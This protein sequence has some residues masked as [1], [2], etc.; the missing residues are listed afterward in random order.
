M[1]RMTTEI[2]VGIFVV[3]GLLTLIYMTATIGKWNLGRSKGYLVTARL[4]SASGLLKDSPVK[5]L[6][7]SKGKIEKL[8]IEKGKAK[9]YMRLPEELMLPKDSLVFV[10]SEGLLGEKYIEIKPGSPD[11]PLITD[12][13]ELLQ[14]APP[15]DLDELFSELSEVARSIK[16]L[17]QIIIQPADQAGREKGKAGAIQSI[18]NNLEKTSESLKNLAQKIEKGEGTLGKLLTDDAMYDELKATLADISSSIGKLSSSEGTLGKLLSDKEVYNTIKEITTRIN[19][20]IKKMERG[21]GVLGKFFIGETLYENKEEKQ[22]DH[23]KAS[24][25]EE[26]MPLTALGSMLGKVTE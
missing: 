25:E 15:A 24:P 20:L 14:G 2:K 10:R 16:N 8:A 13:G 12:M 11:K 17:T 21:E 9:V 1:A 23:S 4:D 6:G 7:V 26:S 19:T 18:I 3:L 5:V 22:K